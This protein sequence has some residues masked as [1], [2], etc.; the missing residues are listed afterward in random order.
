M[1]VLKQFKSFNQPIVLRWVPNNGGAAS[2][3]REHQCALV[4]L[5]LPDKL[6]CVCPERG[7][8][9]DILLHT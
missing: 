4:R 7:D 3:L 5:H 9:L 1:D 2:P 8:R 6:G